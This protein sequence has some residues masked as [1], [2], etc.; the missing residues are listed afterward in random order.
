MQ[1]LLT[2]GFQDPG[3]AIPDDAQID[4]HLNP[5]ETHHVVDA[6]SSQALAIHDVSQGRN[7]VI[8]GPPGT[9]KSQTIT[10]LIA[11]AISKG[12]RVLFVAEKMAALEVVKRNLDKVGLGDACLELHSHKMNKKAVVDELKRILELGAPRTTALE[13]EVRLLLSNRDD[14]NGYCQAVNT[15]IGESGITPYEAYGE[16]LAVER[17]LSG[18]ELPPLDL[19][20]FQHSASEFRS[21]LEQTER[22]Q[23]HLKGM[24]IPINH[25][26][27][28][29]RC[30]VFLP[31]D[32]ESLERTAAEARE[33][34]T[35]LKDSSKQ[36]AQ[37]LRFPMP[38]TCEAVESLIRAA[39]RAL[40][41]PNLVGVSVQST[42]WQTHH[43]DLEVGLS[44]GKRLSELHSE[45]DSILSPEA[46]GA[47]RAGDSTNVSSLWRQMVEAISFGQISTG[48]QGTC[49]LMHA[50]TTQNPRSATPYR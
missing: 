33:T 8:Q 21:G 42:E 18:V 28:G 34:V 9:G 22:L 13:E 44:A 19:H 11:E 23:A 10:N 26:F 17:R 4:E 41:A 39:R 46:W 50:T 5:T 30:G 47:K 20:Q 43:S 6:D 31:T 36:L 32:R 27:W 16:L 3:S 24:G 12:K 14:L 49:R 29:S 35:A 45:H 25:P 40:D 7:L 38:D 2:T 1:S 37:H 15:P 48:M